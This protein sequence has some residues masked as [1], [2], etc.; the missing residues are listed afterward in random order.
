MIWAGRKGCQVSRR[1]L[2]AKWP[3]EALCK[4]SG[5]SLAPLVASWA[6]FLHG[7][8]VGHGSAGG[9]ACGICCRGR[10]YS[11]TAPSGRTKLTWL[12]FWS[13]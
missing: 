7:E 4:L 13:H 9:A 10:V 3:W 2:Q 6:S 8:A 11:I 5:E 1:Y 12:G